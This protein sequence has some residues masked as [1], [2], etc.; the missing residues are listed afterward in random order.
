MTNCAVRARID[1][2][3][4][5]AKRILHKSNQFGRAIHVEIRDNA[6]ITLWLVSGWAS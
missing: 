4:L 5:R 1:C 2:D 3:L 6:L